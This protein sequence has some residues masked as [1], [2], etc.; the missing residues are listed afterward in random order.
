[1]DSARSGAAARRADRH[2][3]R[4]RRVAASTGTRPAVDRDSRASPRRR[5][6]AA[7][8]STV[9]TAAP[10]ALPADVPY[11]AEITAAAKRNGIDPALL[12]GLVKQES[13]FNPNAGSARRRPR[14]DPADAGHRRRPRRH[15]R[16]RPRPVARRRREVPQA[17]ARRASAATS[18]G[19]SPPTTP[20]PAPSSASAAS[21]R[22]PRRRTT[23]ARCRPTPPHT[24]PPAPL[25]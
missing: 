18:P 6:R 11:A 13:G 23:S 2:G 24:G 5:H 22:T 3:R 10:S 17:A 16:A 20:A 15:Q 25:R 8:A 19:R 21:R 1:M 12:A 4:S 9:A 7:D 14:P